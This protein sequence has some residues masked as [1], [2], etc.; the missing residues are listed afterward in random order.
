MDIFENV[1]EGNNCKLSGGAVYLDV[2]GAPDAKI[3]FSRNVF[4][5]N[6]VTDL[7]DG[8]GGYLNVGEIA[9]HVVFDHNFFSKNH[10]Y[11]NGGGVYISFTNS[12]CAVTLKLNGNKFFENGAS[13]N[14]GGVCVVAGENFVDV[15]GLHIFFTNNLFYNKNASNFG[16]GTF[17]FYAFDY[18]FA[19]GYIDFINNTYC[20]N[21]SGDHGGGIEMEGWNTRGINIYN[22]IFW[23]NSPH[24][25]SQSGC[26]DDVFLCTQQ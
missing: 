15:K 6:K 17:L 8:G 1:F 2:K 9:G 11:Q 3:N 5:E 10:V 19:C 4:R 24:D 21:H 20:F 18:R 13:R 16:V 14:G 7:G 23:K 22:N 12:E 25:F 26:D